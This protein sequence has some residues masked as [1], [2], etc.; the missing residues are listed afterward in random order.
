MIRISLLRAYLPGL[1]SLLAALCLLL[2]PQLALAQY[3]PSYTVV[4]EHVQIDVKADGSHRYRMQRAIRIDTAQGVE[5]QGEQRFSYVESLKTME[6]LE[7]YAELPDGKRIPV[8]PDQIRTHD[9]ADDE[10]GRIFSDRK[11]KVVIYPKVSIGTVLY[12]SLDSQQHTPFFPG[13]FFTSEYLWPSIPV[14]DY[15]LDL[16]HEAGIPIQVMAQTHEGNPLLGKLGGFRL[17]GGRV[18]ALPVDPPGAV[19]YAYRAVQPGAVPMERDAVDDEDFAAWIGITSFAD[20][21]ALGLAYQVRARPNSEPDETIRLLAASLTAKAGSDRERVRILHDWVAQNIRY[22]RVYVGAGGFVPRKASVILATRYGDCK[23]HVALLEAL[24]RAV[25]IESSPALLNSGYAYRFRAIAVSTPI[26][27]VIT[28]I[29]SLNLF[30]DATAQ[31][32]PVGTLP[33]EAMDKPVV[34]AAT[35]EVRRTQRQSPDRDNMTVISQMEMLL[36][37]R[38]RGQSLMRYSG[39]NEVRSRAVWHTRQNRDEQNVVDSILGRTQESGQGRFE[40]GDPSNLS[41]DWSIRSAYELDEVANLTGVSA[42]TIPHGLTF[43]P[44][45]YSTGERKTSERL[46]PFVCDMVFVTEDIKLSLPE[47]L[48]ITQIPP[49]QL[50]E[51]HGVRYESR[52]SRQG[53]SIRIKRSL[54]IDYGKSVCDQ[55][56]ARAWEMARRVIRRDFRNQVFV[57]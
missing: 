14:L 11:Q 8:D 29:P 47:K 30:L 3:K 35:G 19:R 46:T 34:I 2:E 57:R 16:V 7:A 27:H 5:Q 28:Y 56:D 31:F 41:T 42:F 52:Y 39:T 21:G 6:I 43:A 1:I 10:D 13:H 23:D 22:L 54:L 32:A 17:E 44:I 15:R 20:W 9:V 53:Q 37:G 36:D 55:G 18:T 12:V 25:G 24:L 40:Y 26:N 49:D 45:F 33:A 51:G 50:H 38:L 4:R 48:E